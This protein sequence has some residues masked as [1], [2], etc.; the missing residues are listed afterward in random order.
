M[1]PRRWSAEQLQQWVSRVGG[2]K[3]GACAER[4]PGGLT[5]AQFTR[6]GRAQFTQLCGA[7]P[8]VGEALWVALQN[9]LKRVADAAAAHRDDLLGI[10]DED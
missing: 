1:H 9:E 2:G 5:G 7:D 8:A 4:L 3:F 10:I 6:W